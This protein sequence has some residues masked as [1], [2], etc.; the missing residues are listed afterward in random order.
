VCAYVRVCV[1]A[2][3]RGYVCVREKSRELIGEVGG[4][5][6]GGVSGSD[7]KKCSVDRV[8]GGEDS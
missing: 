5:G 3:A 8:Q 4:K 6:G 2:R 1:C 7:C